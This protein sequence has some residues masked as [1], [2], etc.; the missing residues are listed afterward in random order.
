[1]IKQFIIVA[2]VGP[3]ALLP[4]KAVFADEAETSKSVDNAVVVKA[5]GNPAGDQAIACPVF[6][7][8]LARRQSALPVP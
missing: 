5:D 2:G 1:M 7:F 3:L 6:C 4:L 8:A